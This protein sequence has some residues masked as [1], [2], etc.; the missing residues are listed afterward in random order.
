MSVDLIG[1][2]RSFKHVLGAISMVAPVDSAVMLLGETER[3]KR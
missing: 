1:T 3:E 2:S